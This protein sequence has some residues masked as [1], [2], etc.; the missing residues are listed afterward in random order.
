MNRTWLEQDAIR[1]ARELIQRT[2]L[3]D[4][5]GMAQLAAQSRVVAKAFLEMM[6]ELEG[7]RS[8]H[9]KLRDQLRSSNGSS[10]SFRLTQ[11][12]DTREC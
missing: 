10:V 9:V 1:Q 5:L 2:E 4:E 11:P 6:V 8:A 7:L 12:S 3:F